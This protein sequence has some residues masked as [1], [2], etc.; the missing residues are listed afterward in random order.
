[1]SS[2]G[3]FRRPRGVSE[4]PMGFLKRFQGRNLSRDALVN[5]RSASGDFRGASGGLINI[6]GNPKGFRR[7]RW[8]HRG[9]SEGLTSISGFFFQ[10]IQGIFRGFKGLKG[11]SRGFRVVSE[12]SWGFEEG[13][14]EF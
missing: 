9:F 5:L 6:S 13:F 7:V 8:C 4:V 1:M 10:E 14:R 12:S 2:Q 11:V 3:C